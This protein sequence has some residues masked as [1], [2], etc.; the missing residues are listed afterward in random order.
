MGE[1]W[2]FAGRQ[3]CPV[4]ASLV[5]SAQGDFPDRSG[6]LVAF[7]VF[8]EKSWPDPASLQLRAYAGQLALTERTFHRCQIPRFAVVWMVAAT[9]NP[10][11]QWVVTGV[12]TLPVVDHSM[13]EGP[14]VESVWV[15][16]ESPS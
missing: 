12:M 6:C 8:L 4:P 15:T 5:R 16:G 10:V 13:T 1:E 9:V 3:F 11:L 7:S 14:R 2:Y